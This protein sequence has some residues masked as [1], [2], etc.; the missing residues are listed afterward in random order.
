[1]SRN[2]DSLGGKVDEIVSLMVS[3]ICG[4]C[5]ENVD[6]C[7]Y[8]KTKGIANFVCSKGHKNE[9]KDFWLNV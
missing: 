7:S 5:D 2:L 6:E 3:F 1:M 9:I 8:N 4:F